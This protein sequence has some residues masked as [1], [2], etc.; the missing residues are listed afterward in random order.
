MLAVSRSRSEE[1]A[2]GRRVVGGFHASFDYSELDAVVADDED[3]CRAAA[4]GALVNASLSAKRVHEVETGQEA[5]DV[6]VR[7]QQPD[8]WDRLRPIIVFLDLHIAGCME[9]AKEICAL[10]SRGQLNREPFLV[11]FSARRVQNVDKGYF[12]LTVPKTFEAMRISAVLESCRRWHAQGGGEPGLRPVQF[13]SVSMNSLPSMGALP[14]MSVLPS[15]GALPSLG[16][17]PDVCPAKGSTAD[18][19]SSPESSP[20]SM[21]TMGLRRGMPVQQN[22]PNSSSISM[23]VAPVGFVDGVVS[24]PT[25]FIRRTP[26]RAAVGVQPVRPIQPVKPV[27]PVGVVRECDEAGIPPVRSRQTMQTTHK[28]APPRAST[29]VTPTRI[30]GNTVD[31]LDKMLPPR[32]PFEDVEMVGLVGRGSF[33]RVY[34]ARWGVAP[35]ALKVVE[36]DDSCQS[37]PDTVSFEGALSA[38]LAH[39][40][41]VQ[42]F[43]YS[44]REVTFG[45]QARSR[46]EVGN[47]E[48]WIVQEWCGLGTLAQ[49][50]SQQQ[51]EM[52]GGSI[53]EVVEVACEIVC[54]ASYLHS[55]GVIHGDL[56]A[57]NVLLTERPN[58]TKGYA[59]KVSDFGLAR[60]L[61]SGKSSINTATMGTVTYM[62]PELFQLE[63][64]CLTQKVDV[65]AFGVI[66]W[67][68][69]SGERPFD[70]LLPTQ[71]VVIVSQGTSL[72]MPTSVPT[73]LRDIFQHCTQR[74]PEMRPAFDRLLVDLKKLYEACQAGFFED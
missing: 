70:G 45:Q 3:I 29:P 39:P 6:V 37:A 22:G 23:G 14:S 13:T 61:D 73:P 72:K 54:G 1:V 48:V 25:N 36:H 26:A 52:M 60:V 2:N 50:V 9:T 66:L 24:A 46:G 38:S 10:A 5:L 55:R 65:Y 27:L 15:L 42:T 43:K 20:T 71:I 49:R 56:T 62:P 74:K 64:C 11:C 16:G 21:S 4:A 12:H 28:V 33:G 17:L 30:G 68:M 32:P 19:T 7:L 35:V 41:L 31:S 40:N 67:Q 18:S 34:E 53:S 57:S 51:Q 44:V 59:A 47:Y 58:C 8:S 69:C 63:G